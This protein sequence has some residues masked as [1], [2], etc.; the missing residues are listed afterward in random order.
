MCLTLLMLKIYVTGTL[1]HIKNLQ[2]STRESLKEQNDE[3]NH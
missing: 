3:Q 2:E 1:A